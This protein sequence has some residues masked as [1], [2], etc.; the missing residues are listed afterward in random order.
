M[1]ESGKLLRR[2]EICTY[3]SLESEMCSR[4][5][6]YKDENTIAVVTGEKCKHETLVNNA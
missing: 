6:I 3:C 1:E 4:I 5:N 2:S